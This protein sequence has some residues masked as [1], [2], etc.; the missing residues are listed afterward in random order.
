MLGGSSGK[1]N[2]CGRVLSMVRYNCRK[3][4]NVLSLVHLLHPAQPF[5]D[6]ENELE[7]N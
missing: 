3:K 1:R 4:V 2:S 6:E 5:W 7:I